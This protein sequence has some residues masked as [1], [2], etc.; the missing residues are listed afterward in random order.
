[1]NVWFLSAHDQPKGRSSRTY[2]FSLELVRR[3]HQV[4]MFTNSYDHWTHEDFLASHEKWRIE[5]IDGIRVV[6]MQ[7]IKYTGNGLGRGMNMLS[8]AWRCI[9]VART[10][11]DMPDVVV[12]PSVP[13]L[14]GWAAS[15]IAKMKGA[16]FVFE[17]R[18]VWPIALADNGVL[19]KKNPVFHVFRYIEKYLYS[20]S[21][22]ISSTLPFL[23]QH[24]SDSGSDPNKITWIPNGV[25]LSRFSGFDTYDGGK[26]TPIV[27][28]YVG[29]MGIAQD[30]MT[31]VKAASILQ[32]KGNKSFSFVIVGN[33]VRLPEYQEEAALNKLSN[34]EFRDS[35]K[36]SAVPK[37]QMES[38]VLI[39]SVINSP[40][41]RFGLNLNK[42]YDY[43]ASSRPVIFSGNVK[44]DPVAET[45]AGFSIPPEDPAAMVEA[46]E[47][48]LA[49]SL[50]ERAE[51][52]KKGRKFIEKEFD[53]R[54]LGDRMELLL[55]QAVN[56]GKMNG[57]RRTKN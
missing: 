34:I 15:R 29:A 12:G 14:T 33:G 20:K 36:K 24:V 44:N 57:F 6:W 52:G 48:L 35:V 7:T 2:D 8:N 16:A 53:I 13:L 41:Y 43:F 42:V 22:R 1:M 32:K 4:T 28:M 23:Y 27:V 39:A 49:M 47:K 11:S 26:K 19:S 50:A 38:D 40:I 54:V 3:G 56:E 5:E 46:L 51:M 37:L 21:Q 9:Q 31:I 30:V 55:Q 10:L 25:N 45:G 18:D 17:V